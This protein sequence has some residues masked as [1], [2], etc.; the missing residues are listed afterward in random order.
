[1]NCSERN[2]RTN[3][4]K[5]MMLVPFARLQRSYSSKWLIHFI[6]FRIFFVIFRI[7]T[8]VSRLPPVKV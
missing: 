1:M 2:M 8:I 3:K 6:L 4:H 7:L 5:R